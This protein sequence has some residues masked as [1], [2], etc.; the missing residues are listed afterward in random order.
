MEEDASTDPALPERPTGPAEGASGRRAWKSPDLEVEDVQ[1]VYAT[2][3]ATEGA[4][5]E[6]ATGSVGSVQVETL[7]GPSALDKARAQLVHV[8]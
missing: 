3:G 7:K 2:G 4:G 6:A 5:T 1:N 8:R